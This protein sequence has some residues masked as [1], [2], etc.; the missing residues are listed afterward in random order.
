MVVK[1]LSSDVVVEPGKEPQMLKK[2]LLEYVCESAFETKAVKP[3][4]FQFLRLKTSAEVLFFPIYKPSHLQSELCK[5]VFLDLFD[6]LNPPII[7][8]H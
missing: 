4:R 2:D 7:N 8:L 5:W 6:A 1:N 3:K